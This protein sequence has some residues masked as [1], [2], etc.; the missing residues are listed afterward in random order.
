MAGLKDKFSCV[1]DMKW[2]TVLSIVAVGTLRLLLPLSY[3][4]SSN[5]S[6]HSKA[7][8]NVVM[9]QLNNTSSSSM[10]C[11]WWTESLLKKAV[12]TLLMALL[13]V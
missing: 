6:A 12:Y 10:D 3:L 9:K 5:V 11:R 1:Q 13:S 7:S 8:F 2:F 4:I